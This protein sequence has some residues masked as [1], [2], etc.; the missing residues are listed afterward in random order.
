MCTASCWPIAAGLMLALAPGAVQATEASTEQATRLEQSISGWLA[1]TLGPDLK[2]PARPVQV[3]TVGDA[4]R[5]T[6]PLGGSNPP[7]TAMLRAAE[8][9]TWALQGAQFP[10]PTRFSLDLPNPD[11]PR[12]ATLR[13]D[14]ALSWGEQDASGLFDPN[15]QVPSTLA[16]RSVASE[17][18][19]SSDAGRSATRI[20]RSAGQAALRPAGE[21]VFDLALESTGKGYTAASTLPSGQLL[22]IDAGAMRGRA[23]V[24]GVS[25]ERAQR[26][27]RAVA[28]AGSPEPASPAR[29]RALIDPMQG[30]AA[31]AMVVQAAQDLRV[32][33]G[34]LGWTAERAA[35]EI[36]IDTPGGIL[37]LTMNMAAEGI[38]VQDPSLSAAQRDL[39]PRRV[40]LRPVVSGIAAE[41]LLGLLL[42]ATAPGGPPQPPDPAR[43][44]SRGGLAVGLESFALDIG[45]ASFAGGGRMTMPTLLDVGGEGQVEATGF[46]ALLERV[47]RAQELSGALP[48]LAFAKGIARPVGDRLVWDI[49]YRGGQVLE[50]N[51]IKFGCIRRV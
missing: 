6:A 34:G 29:M 44:F 15:Q 36:G 22:R 47:K 18:L 30:L 35:L 49:S 9:G 21:G 11:G 31:S 41:D 16:W 27:V 43:L 40:A 50:H 4:Y 24:S 8:G 39:A 48:M 26:L 13:T 10:S 12:G 1:T 25:R 46:E 17:L 14:Y 20:A 3:E 19:V 7:L 2:L 23:E 42:D 38:Q 37:A 32:Q 51:R 45:G 5:L 33:V 28:A